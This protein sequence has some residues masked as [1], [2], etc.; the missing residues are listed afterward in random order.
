MLDT[1]DD[2]F[3]I[4]NYILGD[5]HH[6]SFNLTTIQ[7]FNLKPDIPALQKMEKIIQKTGFFKTID[8]VNL[9]INVESPCCSLII[10]AATLPIKIIDHIMLNF[11]FALP[12]IHKFLFSMFRNAINLL[13]HI[14]NNRQCQIV[15]MDILLILL[16]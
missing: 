12:V 15:A 6:D 9:P 2:L 8:G 11:F 4:Q 16:I 7:L 10:P 5:S 3:H 1:I 13:H 14:K